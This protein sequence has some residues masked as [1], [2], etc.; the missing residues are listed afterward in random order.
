MLLRV[1][2]TPKSSRDAVDGIV[3]TAD[4]SALKLRVRAVPEDGAANKALLATIAK[5]LH[6]PKSSVT[7]ASGAKSRQKVVAI[8]AGHDAETLSRRLEELTSNWK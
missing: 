5:W 3:D 7:L 2:L 8:L 6:Q 1:R 4:G